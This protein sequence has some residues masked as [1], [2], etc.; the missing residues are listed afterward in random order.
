MN[1]V[2]VMAWKDVRL[3][4]RDKPGMFFTFLLPIVMAVFFGLVFGGMGKGGGA[5]M[6]ILVVDLDHSAGSEQFI[7]RLETSEELAVTRMDDLAAAEQQVRAGE[8]TAVVTLPK[9]FGDGLDTLFAGRAIELQVGVDPA[10]KAES[11]M[12]EGVLTRYAFMNLQDAF[13]DT[14]A[15]RKRLAKS[16]DSV[17]ADPNVSPA[18]KSVLSDLFGKLDTFTSDLDAAV[19]KDDA[20]AGAGQ[21]SG[22]GTG[23]S[24]GGFSPVRITSR[25]ITA[26]RDGPTNAYAV[27]FPQGMVWGLIACTLSFAVSIVLERVRGTLIRLRIAPITPG[28]LLAGKALACFITSAALIGGLLLLAYLVF[29]VRPVRPLLLIPAIAATSTCFVGIMMVVAAVSK[30]EAAANGLGWGVLMLA[31]MFGGGM[32]PLFLLK[33]WMQAASNFS[34]VKWSVLALEGAIWRGFT[35]AEMARPC[36]ILVAIG[37][38]GFIL[39]ARGMAR[40]DG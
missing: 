16:R 31:A 17:T 39:G 10:R 24:T 1:S 19:A 13:T 26:K 32:I 23:A 6:R 30:T 14:S 18:V 34:P 5:A 25:E 38:A 8:Q 21:E 33:G 2:L 36:L 12:L 22:E 20:A 7:H 15:M 4:L 29:G 37:V 40:A 11:G 27:T 9:G 35:P 28:Q 3:L